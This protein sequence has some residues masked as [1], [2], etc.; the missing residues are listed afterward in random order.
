VTAAIALK[1][2]TAITLAEPGVAAAESV[3][4]GVMEGMFVATPLTVG[5]EDVAVSCGTQPDITNRQ[6]N[7]ATMKRNRLAIVNLRVLITALMF[8]RLILPFPGSFFNTAVR[9]IRRK[10]I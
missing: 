4:E 1:T 6:T 2:S 3:V 9:I 8:Y 10:N 5:V 7:I